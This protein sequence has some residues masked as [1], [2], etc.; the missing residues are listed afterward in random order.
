MRVEIWSDVVCPWCYLGKKRF[1]RALA[2]FEHG[3]EVE[4]VYRSFELDP[5][6]PQDR[7]TPTVELLASKYRMTPEQAEQAQRQ[8]QER[9]AADGLTFRMDGLRSGN[10]KDAH[11]VLQLARDAGKQGEMMERLHRAYFTDQESVFDHD[12]LVRLA[13]DAGLDGDAVRAMLASDDYADH[14]ETDE[15]MARALGATGVPLFVID[16]KYGISGAQPAQAI[17]QVLERAWAEAGA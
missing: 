8:M 4:V 13:A 6:A 14:V 1:E 5:D 12:S 15:E 7:T 17:T 2:D 9:A 16:R 3:D 11:R 10:T